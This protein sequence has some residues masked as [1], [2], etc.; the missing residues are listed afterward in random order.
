MAVPS[1]THHRRGGSIDLTPVNY[2]LAGEKRTSF[3]FSNLGNFFNLISQIHS[4]STYSALISVAEPTGLHLPW[5]ETQQKDFLDKAEPHCEKTGLQGFRPG[6]TQTRLYKP[7]E[8]GPW[9]TQPVCLKELII[10]N[11]K[12]QIKDN[13]S[14]NIYLVAQLSINANEFTMFGKKDTK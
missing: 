4:I 8:R 12:F 6:P 10:R 3:Y 2:N 14:Q 13:H 5:S 9:S 11:S 7:P 1:E